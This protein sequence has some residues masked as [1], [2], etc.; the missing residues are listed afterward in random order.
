MGSGVKFGCREVQ[1]NLTIDNIF[2]AVVQDSADLCVVEKGT[3]FV[4]G[5]CNSELKLQ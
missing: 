4:I 2:T 5:E 1:P 3:S